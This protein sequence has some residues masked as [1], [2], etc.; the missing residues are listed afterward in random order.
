MY[1]FPIRAYQDR[2]S[3]V[4]TAAPDGLGVTNY[5]FR[6]EAL[7]A[8]LGHRHVFVRLFRKHKRQFV[9]RFVVLF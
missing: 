2:D 1:C 8:K 4:L 6:T 5:V 9:T 3:P 7:M